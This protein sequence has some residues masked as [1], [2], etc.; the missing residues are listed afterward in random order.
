MRRSIFMLAIAMIA[1]AGVVY[2]Q[3]VSKPPAP[4][5]PPRMDTMRTPPCILPTLRMISPQMVQT[6]SL[7]L[8]LTDDQKTKVAALLEKAEND[9]KPKV[10]A[11]T[12]AGQAYIDLL[13]NPNATKAQINA[14]ADKTMKAETDVLTARIDTLFALK[15]LLNA[16]QNKLLAER[17]EQYTSPWRDGGRAVPQPPAAPANAPAK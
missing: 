7:R 15:G 8:N 17:L 5:P 2:A 9:I 16:E 14:A 3:E 4:P 11:Q 1:S 6:L 10:E 12:K 13:I